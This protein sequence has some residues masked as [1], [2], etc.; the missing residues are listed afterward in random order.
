MKL[1]NQ[2]SIAVLITLIVFGIQPAN[3]IVSIAQ[4]AEIP[5]EAEMKVGEEKRSC[6]A[7][8][9]QIRKKPS[10]QRSLPNAI[11]Y[12]FSEKLTRSARF[13]LKAIPHRIVYCCYL[14]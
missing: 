6:I 8:F 9:S 13:V 14:L 7:H 11:T 5:H 2:I 4:S 10:I 12:Y 3:R 1:L